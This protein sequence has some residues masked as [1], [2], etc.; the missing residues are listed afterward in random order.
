MKTTRYH[1]TKQFGIF[2]HSLLLKWTIV[3]RNDVNSSCNVIQFRN[4]HRFG[5]WIDASVAKSGIYLCFIPIQLF[6]CFALRKIIIIFFFLIYQINMNILYFRFQNHRL[7]Y[8]WK[9]DTKMLRNLYNGCVVGWNLKPF[10]RNSQIC[11]TTAMCR[12]R[13]FHA[14]R[15]PLNVVIQSQQFVIKSGKSVANVHWSRSF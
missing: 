5:V 1:E 8:Y 3:A 12:V 11:N 6:T 14:P 13:V 2:Y 15:A 9:I 4:I 10:A 7:G